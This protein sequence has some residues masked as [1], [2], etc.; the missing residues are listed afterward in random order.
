M[1]DE[2]NQPRYYVSTE[3]VEHPCCW[4][5]TVSDRQ[6]QSGNMSY[7]GL[8]D[9]VICETTEE[10]AIKIADLLNK[11]E[12]MSDEQ[13]NP[14]ASPEEVA[15]LRDSKS[16]KEW[17]SVMIQIRDARGG[18]YPSDLFFHAASFGG[19]AA[20]EKKWEQGS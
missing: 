4:D 2:E 3:N 5:A 17:D 10:L 16:R 6:D 15:A 12:A 20:M 13:P 19:L 9:S 8:C 14:G 1:S 18:Q 7:G 11:A